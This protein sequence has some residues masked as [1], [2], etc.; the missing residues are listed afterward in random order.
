MSA[1][2]GPRAPPSPVERDARQLALR[3]AFAAALGLTI[4][5]ARDQPLT[6]LAPLLAVQ[7]VAASRQAPT[8]A[9]GVGF[10]VVIAAASWIALMIART[11][12]DV[13]P[14]LILVLGVVFF[15]SFLLDRLGRGGPLPS[16]LLT[17]NAAVPVLAM[18]SPG[19]AAGMVW[20]LTEAGITAVLLTWAVHAFF[21]AVALPTP[22]PQRPIVAERGAERFALVNVLILMPLLVS[23]LVEG[24]TAVVV[25]LTVI[26]I[27]RQPMSRSGRTAL[28]LLAGNV[29]GG[30]AALAVFQSALMLPSLI[31]LCLSTLAVSLVLAGRIATAGAT[32]PIHV[33]GLG[34]FLILLGLGLSPLLPDSGEAFVDRVIH[35]GLAAIYALAAIGVL[36][37]VRDGGSAPAWVK[38]S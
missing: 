7:L 29:V 14:V 2:R 23:F 27:L 15:L 18:Q 3:I 21:P 5:E 30:V 4:G 12:I 19:L 36:R 16:L 10:A 37:S 11:L 32:A 8:L 38:P 9:Q 31:F 28:G 1:D 22:P 33:V 25:L 20:L 26:S 35:V 13:P 34:T 24:E 17:T 6:F